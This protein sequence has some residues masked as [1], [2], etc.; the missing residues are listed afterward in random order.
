VGTRLAG[1]RTHRSR[2]FYWRATDSSWRRTPFAPILGATVT[3][4][5]GAENE[6]DGAVRRSASGRARGGDLG[7]F[8]SGILVG[9]HPGGDTR[10]GGGSVVAAQ[11]R[12]VGSGPREVDRA[13]NRH[14][15]RRSAAGDGGAG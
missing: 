8:G 15:A 2:G 11:Y 9:V 1:L 10:G 5:G 14:V 7:H 12:P 13:R 6:S 4:V 3:Q